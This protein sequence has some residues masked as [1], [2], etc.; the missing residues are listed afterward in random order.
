MEWSIKKIGH[1]RSKNEPK[2]ETMKKTLLFIAFLFSCY[3]LQAQ[4]ISITRGSTYKLENK[5]LVHEWV[6]GIKC[7]TAKKMII[8]ANN[9][10]KISRILN[11]GTAL[12]KAKT[13]YYHPGECD[14]IPN[15]FATYCVDENIL[16]NNVILPKVTPAVGI[17]TVPFRY[18]FKTSKIFAGG[19][20]GGYLGAQTRIKS[21]PLGKDIYGF[22][23]V[24]GGYSRIPLN[25]INASDPE[26]TDEVG[27]LGYGGLAG[28]TIGNFQAVFVL[29][30]DKYNLDDQKQSRSWISFGLGYAFI[31]PPSE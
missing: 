7:D 3:F 25:N 31:K 13:A 26:N 2:I 17:L 30:T 19:Q 24:T 8:C 12:I 4:T 29:A 27:A 15:K 21:N 11:D 1:I 6:N 5:I 28:I 9:K 22:I 20:L 14:S 18:D 10:I 16:G 23:G